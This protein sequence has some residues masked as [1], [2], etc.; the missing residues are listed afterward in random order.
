MVR[1][2]LITP[3]HAKAYNELVKRGLREHPT[4]FDT[5]IAAIEKRT[6][7][8]VAR[9]LR[10]FGTTHGYILGAFEASDT[11]VGTAMIQRRN[12]SKQ[13]HVAEV[14][15]VYVPIEYQGK[16]IGKKLMMALLVSARRLEG[17]EQLSLTVNLNGSAARSLYASFGFQSVG[18]WPRAICVAG[19]YFDQEHMWL[20]L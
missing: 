20:P 11:L 12:S 18:I 1:I 6:V 5:D 14:L 16:G 10:Q 8:S 15:F 2:A 13:A 7:R 19:T 17:I 4:A 3:G 9:G